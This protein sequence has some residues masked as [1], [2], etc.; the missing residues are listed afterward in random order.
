M[1]FRKAL[2]LQNVYLEAVNGRRIDN[3][4]VKDKNVRRKKYKQ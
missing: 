3:T 4:M 1:P 2:K